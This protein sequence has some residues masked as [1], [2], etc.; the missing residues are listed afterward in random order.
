MATEIERGSGNVFADI[1]IPD[2]ETH[3]LKVQL[4]IIIEEEIGRRGLSQREAA[5]VMEITQSDVS[6]IVRGTLRGISIE[7]LIRCARRL[8]IDVSLQV[9]HQEQPGA[10]TPLL[11]ETPAASVHDVAAYILSR[12][13]RT[14]AMKLQ[15]LVYYAQAYALVITQR[16]LF[17]ARIEAW[18]KGPVVPVLWSEH[19]GSMSVSAPWP[20]GDPARLPAVAK[21]MVDAALDRFG[22]MTPDKLSD[23]TH[24][25]EPW[26]QAREGVSQGERCNHEITKGAM[27]R[28]Y[29]DRL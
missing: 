4:S 19:S 14:T 18:A 5:E 16:P 28:Y 8:G 23:L 13:R 21:E 15:K 20:Q 12:L 6:H 17:D 22:G 26:L 25:E 9:L 11:A 7:R 27:A 10:S 2:P 1:G 29:A 3:Q 24:E